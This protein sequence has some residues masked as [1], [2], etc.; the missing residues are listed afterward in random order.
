MR[1]SDHCSDLP[2]RGAVR[3]RTRIAI[4][5]TD[6]AMGR[7]HRVAA[8]CRALGFEHHSTLGDVGVLTGSVAADDLCRLRAVP[9][10]LAVEKERTRGADWPRHHA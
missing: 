2:G 1:R 6:E 10:V 9:G 3:S 7:I 4:A 8:A 5:L